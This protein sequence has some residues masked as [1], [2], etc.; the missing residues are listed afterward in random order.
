[1]ANIEN[2]STFPYGLPISHAI[3]VVGGGVGENDHG[4]EDQSQVQRAPAGE[5]SGLAARVAV[6]EQQRKGKTD[7]QTWTAVATLSAVAIYGAAR[8][9]ETAFYARLGTDADTVGLT[10]GVTLARVGTTAAVSTF[11]LILL[12]L[13]GRHLGRSRR[14]L[15]SQGI[16]GKVSMVLLGLVVLIAGA[17]LY[18]LSVLIP[19]VGVSAPAVRIL[20]ALDGGLVLICAGITYETIRHEKS[21]IDSI[22]SFI[23]VAAI[24]AVLFGIAAFTGY[25][26]ASYIMR[27]KPLP[28]PRLSLWHHPI[29]LPWSSGTSG[30]LG[31]SAE[32]ADVTWIGTGRNR[33][34]TKTVLLGESDGSVVLFGIAKKEVLVVPAEDVIVRPTSSLTSLNEP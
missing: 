10:Y 23:A 4:P 26:S 5:L 29:P 12:F 3:V 32:L 30:Y 24:M 22:W 20:I 2:Y 31:I 14:E 18:P 25:H 16:W 6:L 34:P 1:M 11:G 8:F 27:G 7:L 17:W 19:P 28:S 21:S 15:R 9:G 33:V 13:A